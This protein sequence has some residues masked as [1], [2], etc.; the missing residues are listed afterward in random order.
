MTDKDSNPVGSTKL[1][2]ITE[3]DLIELERIIPDVVMMHMQICNHTRTRVM[4]KKVKEILS[5]IRWD[6]G[7]P[8][9]VGTIPVNPTD[10]T[11][12]GDEWKDGGR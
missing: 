9:E 5:N 12:Q 8:L 7:P 1:F 2:S 10:P 11:D 6:Y 3:H 4:L